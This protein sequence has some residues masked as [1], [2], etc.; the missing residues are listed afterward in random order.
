MDTLELVLQNMDNNKK[1][2]CDKTFIAWSKCIM[3]PA[4]NV[5]SHFIC[6]ELLNNYIVCMDM[7]KS[8]KK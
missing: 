8:P 7:N 6:D 4:N 5:E 1:H 2:K 3:N